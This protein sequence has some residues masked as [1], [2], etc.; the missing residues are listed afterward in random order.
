MLVAVCPEWLSRHCEV[1]LKGSAAQTVLHGLAFS[2]QPEQEAGARKV[3]CVKAD[4]QAV[5]QQRARERDRKAGMECALLMSAGPEGESFLH[6][7][8]RSCVSTGAQES[9]MVI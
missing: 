4:Q 2:E 7:A 6:S 3:S 5:I 8:S 1:A 9:S